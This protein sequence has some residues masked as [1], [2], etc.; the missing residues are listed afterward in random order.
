MII[1][2]DYPTTV[3]DLGLQY[4]HSMGDLQDP[5]YGGT[6]PYKAIFC[7]DIPLDRPYIGLIDGRYLQ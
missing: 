6:V 5:I 3:W 7:G 2:G 4:Y 1:V